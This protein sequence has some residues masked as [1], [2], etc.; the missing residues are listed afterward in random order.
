MKLLDIAVNEVSKI[1]GGEEF[2][3]K[4]LFKGYEWNRLTIEERRNL[5]RD[6]F[7]V[8]LNQLLVDVIVPI[9]KNSAKQQKYRKL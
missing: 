7:R 5:G 4:D 8:E 3:V 1:K 2:I 9:G 6:F